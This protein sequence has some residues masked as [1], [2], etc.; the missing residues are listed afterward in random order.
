M[1]AFWAKY[2]SINEHYIK[3]WG[4]EAFEMIMFITKNTWMLKGKDRI[5]QINHCHMKNLLI[6]LSRSYSQILYM[7][8]INIKKL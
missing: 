3:L 8:V 2:F 6:N 7:T 5:N 4:S 1:C